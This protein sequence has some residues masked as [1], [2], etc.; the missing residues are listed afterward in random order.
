MSQILRSV[1]QLSWDEYVLKSGLCRP[2]IKL[3]SAILDKYVSNLDVCR[4]AIKFLSV[5]LDKYILKSELFRRAVKLLSSIVD[6]YVLIC[7]PRR[8]AICCL[9]CLTKTPSNLNTVGQ[10]SSCCLQDW[11][12]YVLKSELSKPAVKRLSP[13]KTNMASNLELCRP[14]IKML[15]AVLDKCVLK[16]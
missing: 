10:Q 7:T 11:N 3:L 9:S 12:K 1:G 4:P 15:P 8:S 14:A 16:S 5:I 2:A 6:K 13:H